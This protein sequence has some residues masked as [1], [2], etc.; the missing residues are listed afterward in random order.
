MK[1]ENYNKYIANIII[2]VLICILNISFNAAYGSY[3][4]II[5]CGYVLYLLYKHKRN[6]IHQIPFMFKILVYMFIIFYGLLFLESFLLR[7]RYSVLTSF[8]LIK[9]SLPLFIIGFVGF[10][11]TTS[12]GI[13]WGILISSFFNAI[14]AILQHLGVQIGNLKLLPRVSSFFEHPNTLASAIAFII[15]FLI[16]FMI[17]SSSRYNKLLYLCLL[18]LD[19]YC[20]YLTDSRGGMVSTFFGILTMIVCIMIKSK[21]KFNQKICLLVLIGGLTFIG[22]FGGMIYQ[23]NSNRGFGERNIMREASIEMWKDHKILGVGL[24]RWH[25]QYYSKQYHPKNGKETGLMMPHNMPLYFL[26]CAGIIGGIGYILFSCS[27][28]WVIYAVYKKR[29]QGLALPIMA[30]YV[31]FLV[32]G[33]VD[34]TIINKQS[35]FVFFCLL[36]IFVN[37]EIVLKQNYGRNRK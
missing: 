6:F 19:T 27:L 3:F 12:S 34:S 16:Y 21:K 4:F 24:A 13:K 36:G 5:G 35:A 10:I 25:E 23:S 8:E 30:S 29:P 18:S 32:E 15:P 9:Y 1:K 37:Q 17:K 22:I 28:F 31:A 2:C 20:L 11:K 26:S 14:I 33:L 7:D